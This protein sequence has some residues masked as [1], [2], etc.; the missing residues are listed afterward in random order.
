VTLHLRGTGLPPL[1]P[2]P[3]HVV[4]FN[5]VTWETHLLDVSA[6]TVLEAL[7]GAPLSI[8]QVE[9]IVSRHFEA[10][11]AD[12]ARFARTLVDE[13]RAAELI[14]TEPVDPPL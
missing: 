7:A 11:A 13:L 1:C 12:L 8:E 3:E 2:F 4:V 9:G 5:P 14:V 6:A 10:P